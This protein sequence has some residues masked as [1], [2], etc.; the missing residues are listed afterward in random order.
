[1]TLAMVLIAA[2]AAVLAQ[3][4]VG[5]LYGPAFLPAVPAF[6]WLLPGVVMLGTNTIYRKA[7]ASEGMPPISVWSPLLAAIANIAL[8]FLLLPRIG[9][10]GASIASTLA[11]GLMLVTSLVYMRATGRWPKHERTRSADR[12]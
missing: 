2:I 10:V 12:R 4:L 9:I 8:N 7:F 6:L 3:P 11:Y 1:M 5:L